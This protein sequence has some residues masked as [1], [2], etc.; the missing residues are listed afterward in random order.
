MLQ[1]VTE[2]AY[3]ILILTPK[4]IY[5]TLRQQLAYFSTMSSPCHMTSCV[6]G[7]CTQEASTTVDHKCDTT[8]RMLIFVFLMLLNGRAR[9][10]TKEVAKGF[11]ELWLELVLPVCSYTDLKS[12]VHPECIQVF[13]LQVW[14]A[15]NIRMKFYCQVNF[16]ILGRSSKN[17][18]TSADREL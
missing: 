5:C 7:L 14:I 4:H 15:P 6:S 8:V 3:C 18:C 9:S 17:F 10:V 16:H 13:L 2:T 1:V 12:L 11:S